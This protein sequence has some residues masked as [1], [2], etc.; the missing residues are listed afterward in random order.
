MM[1]IFG[2]FH[3]PLP[4]HCRSPAPRLH[5]ARCLCT[6]ASLNLR[7]IVP[8]TDGR[9]EDISY[10]AGSSGNNLR[11]SGG[12]AAVW[13]CC[14]EEGGS[15]RRASASAPSRSM[16][17]GAIRIVVIKRK[18]DLDHHHHHHH[19]RRRGG[20]SSIERRRRRRGG[21]TRPCMPKTRVL[22]EISA[23]SDF[24]FCACFPKMSGLAIASRSSV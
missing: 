1:M 20:G 10:L 21:L 6:V 5:S 17:D 13:C 16:M 23:K 3:L 8:Q 7:G 19:R 11:V 2:H 15:E 18:G 14:R 24:P 12:M 22:K 9:T 4:K